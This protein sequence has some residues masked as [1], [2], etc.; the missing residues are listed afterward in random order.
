MR[1]FLDIKYLQ[2]G[3]PRQQQAY[4][5]LTQNNILQKL[6]GFTPILVGTIPIN[7]DI[8]ESD[9][10]IICQWKEKEK[11]ISLLKKEFEEYTKFNLQSDNEKIICNFWIDTFEIEIFGQNTPTTQQYAYRHMLVEHELLEKY[12]EEFRLKIIALKQQG[13]KTEPAFAELLGLKGNPYKEL[14]KYGR[15]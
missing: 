10:D 14:L 15:E 8:E 6:A 1:N 7:I 11:F 13:I 9:L 2:Q 3:T 12:G 4:K 5:V